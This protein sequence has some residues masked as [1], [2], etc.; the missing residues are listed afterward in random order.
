MTKDEAITALE[1]YETLSED[2]G[3][4]NDSSLREAKQIIW[5]LRGGPLTDSYFL[6]KLTCL[7]EWA[8]I[9]FS[10]RKFAKYSGGAQQV[11]VFALGDI[12]TARHLVEKNWPA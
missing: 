3:Y 6:E 8:R 10:T 4:P 9:G 1:R 2:F 5:S 7:E 12:S 11:R